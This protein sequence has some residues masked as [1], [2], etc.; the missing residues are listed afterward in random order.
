[1]KFPLYVGFVGKGR[2]LN[3]L[4]RTIDEVVELDKIVET[5]LRWNGEENYCNNWFVGCV[6]KDGKDWDYKTI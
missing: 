1:M 6:K 5:K 4:E 2:L 3:L